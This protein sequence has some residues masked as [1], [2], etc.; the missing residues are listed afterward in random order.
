MVTVAD[1]VD[2]ADLAL[3]AA[4]LP[5][6]DAAV[7]WVAT[8]ELVDP[9]PYLEGGELL[10][11]TGLSTSGWRREWEAYVQRLVGAG[12]VALGL[13]IGLTHPRSPAALV[14][15][16]ERHGL[17]LL[18][19]PRAT[20]FVAVSRATADLLAEADR[21][22]A[23]EALRLQRELTTAALAS[24][25]ASLVPERLA[26]LVRGAAARVGADGHLLAP[27]AGPRADDLDLDVVGA[28][29]ARIR[30]RGLRASAARTTPDGMVEVHPL[31]VRSR[32]AAYLAVLLPG[33]PSESQRS[34]VRTAVTLLGL[35]AE[36]AAERRD[37]DAALRGRAVELLLAGD[38][39]GAALVLGATFAPIG[40]PPQVTVVRARPSA[41]ATA[42][43]TGLTD[44]LD[45]TAERGLLLT[46]DA[47]ELLAVLPGEEVDAFASAAADAGARVG[48]GESVRPSDVRDSHRT[49]GH[50]LARA[51]DAAPVVSWERIVRDGVLGLLDA[52]RAEDFASRLLAPLDSGELRRT[53]LVFLTHH[54]SRLKAAEEL[55]VHRNTVRHRIAQIESLTGLNLDDAGD[56]VS[57]WI[58]L[59]ALP[60]APTAGTADRR[61]AGRRS[62]P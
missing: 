32:P 50:A 12:V 9:S 7:R 3:V 59:Q 30:P 17:N 29:L 48:I 28:E 60:T 42:D 61:A 47:G 25:D 38:D 20:P 46:R 39:R 5:H 13:A 34:A 52:A 57:A 51:T 33:R 26:R 4:H 55:G 15:A 27:V 45:A 43:D 62:S 56:R 14:R 24:R 10:L 6:P 49:A 21:R 18:E 2:T 19:V 36:R 44:L 54:G 41:S 37:A 1:I 23:R 16:C 22:E 35:A 58:A 31:G 40:V 11:T 8:S 53:L